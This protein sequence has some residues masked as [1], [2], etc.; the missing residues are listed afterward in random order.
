MFGYRRE[1]IE[2]SFELYDSNSI[3]V[4]DDR[5]EIKT[6]LPEK[7]S[8]ELECVT[9]DQFACFKGSDISLIADRDPRNVP[10]LTDTADLS[11]TP[12]ISTENC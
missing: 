12:V 2:L 6:K 1:S 9:F 10:I 7:T 5:F 4:Y 8:Q 3:L 11:C